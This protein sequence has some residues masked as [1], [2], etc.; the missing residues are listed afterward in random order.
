MIQQIGDVP[1]NPLSASQS[2]VTAEVSEAPNCVRRASLEAPSFNLT[3]NLPVVS[4][5][6]FSTVLRGA[7]LPKAGAARRIEANTAVEKRMIELAEAGSGPWRWMVL[8]DG[9][10]QSFIH[11]YDLAMFLRQ[12]VYHT[13]RVKEVVR[14]LQVDSSRFHWIPEC[15]YDLS[16]YLSRCPSKCEAPPCVTHSIHTGADGYWESKSGIG[17]WID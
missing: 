10:R 3:M 14:F 4:P 8:Q 16:G 7:G 11:F 1:A 9:F 2:W 6:Y 13:V 15:Q 12:G 17:S 5:A